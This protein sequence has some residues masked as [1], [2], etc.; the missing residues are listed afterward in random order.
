MRFPQELFA[1]QLW[2]LWASHHGVMPL[3]NIQELMYRCNLKLQ[4]QKSLQDI[5]L[6]FGRGFQNTYGNMALARE[7]IASE[8]DKVCTIRRWDF[9]VE[10]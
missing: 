3:Q 5:R 8:I 6:A 9:F 4:K 2:L 7:Q 1:E 10:R